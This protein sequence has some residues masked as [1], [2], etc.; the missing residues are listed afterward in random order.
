[1]SEHAQTAIDQLRIANDIDDNYSDPDREVAYHL[2]AAT[3]HALIYIG[4]AI[5]EVG[6]SALAASAAVDVLAAAAQ[7]GRTA[8]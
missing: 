6:M 2:N 8:P 1:M 7:L 5:R 3:V 4:D